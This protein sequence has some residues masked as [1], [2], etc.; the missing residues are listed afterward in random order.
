[1]RASAV[2]KVFLFSL[3]VLR[4]SSAGAYTA[5]EGATDSKVI[6]PG[7]WNTNFTE[8]LDYAT[9]NH[10]PVLMYY[11]STGC[12]Y[13]S[14]M[15]SAI[16][17]PLFKDWIAEKPIVLIYKHPTPEQISMVLKAS[18]AEKC[19]DPDL[20]RA[21]MWVKD[22]SA[23]IPDYPR[24]RCWWEEEG[25]AVHNA[26]FCGRDQSMPVKKPQGSTTDKLAE[27]LVATLNLYFSG[28]E[29]NPPYFGGEFSPESY[30]A[31][32]GITEF[33]ALRLERGTDIKDNPA[34]NWVVMSFNGGVSVT[35]A[36]PIV[37]GE[38][39]TAK[40]FTCEL[41]MEDVD[42]SVTN[43]YTAQLLSNTREVMSTATIT[44]LPYPY[45]GGIFVT[46]TEPHARLEA[47]ENTASV[48]VPIRRTADPSYSQQLVIS[49]AGKSP[50][51]NTLTW[52]AGVLSTNVVVDLA[53][54]Y[55]AGKDI[56]LTLLNDKD[57]P[58]GETVIACVETVENSPSNPYWIGER[59][60][61]TLDWGDWT[62]DFAAAT[63]KVAAADGEAYTLV[64]VGGSKWCPD[65]VKTDRWLLEQP[66][67]ADWAKRRNVICVD[68]DLPRVSGDTEGA[69]QLASYPSLL[70]Y[71]S[72]KVSDRY[73]AACEDGEASR[74]QSGAGYLSRHG[75]P[76]TGNGGTNATAVAKRNAQLFLTSTE[77]GGLCRPDCLN[78]TN[79]LTG[80]FKTGIPC[81]I[82]MDR[83]GRIIGRNFQFNNVS[84]A[85]FK[86]C[87]T[88]RLDEL[89]AQESDTSEESNDSWQTTEDR[90]GLRDSSGALSEAADL[91]KSV[92]Y[93]DVRD[94]YRVAD[95]ATDAKVEYRLS[96][97][98]DATVSLAL[99]QVLNGK[100]EDLSRAT[101]SLKDGLSVSIDAMPTNV[102]VCVSSL[103]PG[104]K[105]T[106]GFFALTNDMSTVAKYALTSDAVLVPTETLQTFS[107]AG[108]E[109]AVT[110]QVE[111][112]KFYKFSGEGLIE[113]TR[114]SYNLESGTYR[115]NAS[116]TVIVPL[117]GKAF[118]YQIWNPGL[119]AFDSLVGSVKEPSDVEYVEYTLRIKRAGGVSGAGKVRIDV[120]SERS[121]SLPGV[122]EFAEGVEREHTWE[123]G[124]ADDWT[125]PVRILANEFSDGAQQVVFV[126]TTNGLASAVDLG[127]INEHVLTI[128]DNDTASPGK[129]RIA[130][131]TPAQAGGIV[132]AKAGSS[133][134]V[135]IDRTEGSDGIVGCTLATTVGSLDKTAFAW[136]SRDT[137]AQTA[138]LSL[139]G[140]PA[141]TLATVTLTP[142]VGTKA[143]TSAKTLSIRVLPSNAPE[144]VTNAV[145][146]A[147]HR[148][149]DIGSDKMVEV[150]GSA[151]GNVSVAK[152]SGST[153]GG[154]KAGYG[155]AYGS[156]VFAGCTS[157]AAGRYEAVYQ[158]S[159][160]EV[161]GLVVAV[162]FRVID[163]VKPATETG[164][165]LNEACAKTRTF[166]DLQVY[167]DSDWSRLAGL[168]TVTVPASGR[169]SAKYTC[170]SGTVSLVAKNWSSVTAN[171]TLT[172]ELVG[173][174]KKTSG[175]SMTVSCLANGSVTCALRDPAYKNVLE[176]LRAG[177]SWS[178]LDDGAEPWKGYY[179]ASLAQC[180]A[181]NETI[182]AKGDGYITLKMNTPAAVRKGRMAYAGVLPNGKAFSGSR[183]LWGYYY[184]PLKK[185]VFAYL[186]V[187]SVST[188]DDVSGLVFIKPDAAAKHETERVSV[189]N[190]MEE[191]GLSYKTS[192][193]WTCKDGVKAGLSYEALF[194]VHGG[195]YDQDED[196]YALC[197]EAF[198]SEEG[199]KFDGSLTFFAMPD[200]MDEA[201][202]WSTNDT[203]VAVGITSK[204][205]NA[206]TLEFPKNEQN[207]T[208]SFNLA[209]GLV[210]GMLD[211]PVG[212]G[213]VRTNYKGV[214][215]PGWGT[216]TCAECGDPKDSQKRPFVSGACW[217]ARR[218][219]YQTDSGTK[220][221]MIKRGCPFSVG[222]EKGR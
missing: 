17:L 168:V 159:D 220:S 202:F 154:L 109:E 113:D 2:S 87:Y 84:P 96:G 216:S 193:V 144:F 72:D 18:S 201:A 67:F 26:S 49:Q 129:V 63:Q 204:G 19:A 108:G 138:V 192:F 42:Y 71:E 195:Y 102:F 221:I 104:E 98:S 126:L 95:N 85:E 105:T 4:L 48:I 139:A 24:L 207:L 157:A 82:V 130:S 219:T 56:T 64:L 55:V 137:S 25:G 119:I 217:F 3:F 196:F 35:N 164:R 66:A 106:S 7:V 183:T 91:R 89:L 122:Y 214:V 205:Q 153:P 22:T 132:Y 156:L 209:S 188:S 142:N 60:A 88:N 69:T 100:E 143:V 41:K 133:V 149:V 199:V 30:W 14:T 176:V 197:E 167:S 46:S 182:L 136:Q 36:M 179:T 65:C 5:I 128:E 177:D 211:L 97:E 33:V 11:G 40:E 140:V 99:V 8:A 158:V 29:P 114:L 86:P 180:A 15:C 37:W 185:M 163:P 80:K 148:N 123:E 51:T 27:K 90:I 32:N 78:P 34:T 13:C 38:N 74:Y 174:T 94:C 121:T 23:S 120:D 175:Y 213:T 81:L 117:E 222:V 28:Y 151:L 166:S 58:F 125:V 9:K 59:T 169:V 118:T 112:N 110:L 127:A 162:T 172:A 218:E 152:V 161:K 53:A 155:P 1:M 198:N 47:D 39:E 77:E 215:L 160:G 103:L 165:A 150:T 189:G 210:S 93:H 45:K 200:L 141:G 131:A 186:S 54:W 135:T 181:T 212:M 101:G 145:T 171:G 147:I 21:R 12:G 190:T 124:Q 111:A 6:T 50:V 52:A 79:K 184:E 115:A 146:Y 170:P 134:L 10:I 187:F 20:Y 92:S 83:D 16:N 44:A 43:V 206:L 194:D 70:T 61:D 178:L 191:Y 116:C 68:I 208:L 73:V 107:A 31:T 76:Q 75:I 203:G 173:T 57:E 62:M